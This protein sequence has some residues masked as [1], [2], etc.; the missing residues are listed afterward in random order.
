MRPIRP[1]GL[2]VVLCLST[3]AGLFPSPAR[4]LEPDMVVKVAVIVGPVGEALTP[5]Y[6]GLAEAA[7]SAAESRG[8]RVSRAYSPAATPANVLAAVED[9][10]IV[11]YLGHG[12]GT[13]NPYSSSPD[14][15]ATNG[16][17]LQGPNA[18][19]PLRLMGRR[20]AQVLRGGMDRGQRTAGSGLGDDLLERLLRA[21]RR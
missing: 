14:P 2:M 8:A 12:V 15:A 4:G 6:I 9:A 18:R 5:V 20:H 11:V 16:W 13:P 19:G 21:G 7:A 3:F 17:G 1:I 10:N